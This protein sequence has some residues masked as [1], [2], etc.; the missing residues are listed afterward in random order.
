MLGVCHISTFSP[1]HCGIAT[2]A[3]DLIASLSKAS[4]TR[5][6]LLN[7]GEREGSG[8]AVIRKGYES[9]YDRAAECVNAN[10]LIDVVSLQHAFGIY[11]GQRG[12]ICSA[13]R[14]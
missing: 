10:P 13:A 12:G 9:D 5:V 11:G 1:T 7:A 14:L 8:A 2:Y 3:E 6:R 4:C